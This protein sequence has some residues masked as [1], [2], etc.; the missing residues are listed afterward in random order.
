MPHNVDVID[1]V[2]ES[3][4]AEH[5]TWFLWCAAESDPSN[6]YHDAWE[7]DGIDHYS[8]DFPSRTV[9]IRWAFTLLAGMPDATYGLVG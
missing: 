7:P 9:G 5:R 1:E 6:P 8:I 4:P 3:L 2:A